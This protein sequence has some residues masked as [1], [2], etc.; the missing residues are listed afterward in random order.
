MSSV[1]QDGFLLIL[2]LVPH[3]SGF[4][5]FASGEL[6]WSNF[7]SV[8]YNGYIENLLGTAKYSAKWGRLDKFLNMLSPWSLPCS[9]SAGE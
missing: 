1:G 4:F 9:L 8:M 6:A 7:F 2:V 3:H 5:L